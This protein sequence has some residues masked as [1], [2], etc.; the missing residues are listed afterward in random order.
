MLRALL[1]VLKQKWPDLMTIPGPIC[2]AVLI[3]GI[4]S[5]FRNVNLVQILSPA[6][7]LSGII[8]LSKLKRE[9]TINTDILVYYCANFRYYQMYGH[10]LPTIEVSRPPSIVSEPIKQVKHEM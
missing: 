2:R 5:I 1:G 9:I 6:L 8:V 7:L 3:G 4:N 10:L